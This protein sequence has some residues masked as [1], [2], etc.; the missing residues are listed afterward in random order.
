[1]DY[2]ICWCKN[3]RFMWKDKEEADKIEWTILKDNFLTNYM[4]I[5]FFQQQIYIIKFMC[6][7]INS[8]IRNKTGYFAGKTSTLYATVNFSTRVM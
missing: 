4:F 7:M 1:M 3:V 8:K 5:F 2:I 6:F